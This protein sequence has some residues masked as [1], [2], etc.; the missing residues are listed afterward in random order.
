VYAAAR[1]LKVSVN[2][3]LPDENDVFGPATVTFPVAA[4]FDAKQLGQLVAIVEAVTKKQL[5]DK[6]NDEHPAPPRRKRR[7]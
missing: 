4:G 6:H 1:L 3:L 2:S 7:K 5:D